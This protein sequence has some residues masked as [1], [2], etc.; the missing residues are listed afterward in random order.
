[1]SKHAVDDDD[2]DNDDDDKGSFSPFVLL[3]ESD[4]QRSAD[5]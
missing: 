4:R 2:D 5:E 3:V 1:M